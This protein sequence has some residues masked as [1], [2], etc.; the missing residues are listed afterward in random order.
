MKFLDVFSS[1]P[2]AHGSARQLVRALRAGGE[3]DE[4]I[5]SVFERRGIETRGLGL[6]SGPERSTEPHS[7][8][9]GL[10]SVA[11]KIAEVARG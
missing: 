9:C 1:D 10:A 11:A 8:R 3:T 5:R 4:S 7:E 6:G 2:E